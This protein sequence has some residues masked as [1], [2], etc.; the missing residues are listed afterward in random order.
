MLT[1]PDLEPMP[2]IPAL[3]PA[4]PSFAER[5][6]SN[7]VRP[8]TAPIKSP[9]SG[10]HRAKTPEEIHAAFKAPPRVRKDDRP[11]PP[12]LP[13]VLRPPLRKKKSF[14]RVSSWLFPG[15]EHNRDLSFD[16]VTNLPRPV[17]GSEGFYQCVSQGEASGRQRRSVDSVDTVST[18][19]TDEG[20]TVP[21]THSPE[22]TP[23][24]KQEKPLMSRTATF[25]INDTRSKRTSVGVAI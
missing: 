24:I 16:S 4:A 3:P 12:P 11:P 18:W 17:K 22:S 7:I 2:S 20:R 8:H 6:N 5:L 14:S 15:S 13:L 10:P 25:G 19:E 21:T 1:T 9:R 23:A